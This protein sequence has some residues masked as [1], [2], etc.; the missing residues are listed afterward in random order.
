MS[1]Q[2]LRTRTAWRSPDQRVSERKQLLPAP[3]QRRAILS[4]SRPQ[5]GQRLY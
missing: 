1:V 5:S 4:R 3:D 2:E